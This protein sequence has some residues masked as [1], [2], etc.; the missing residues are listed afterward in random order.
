MW[1]CDLFVSINTYTFY[2]HTSSEASSPF[3]FNQAWS[4]MNLTGPSK[5]P[6]RGVVLDSPSPALLLIISDSIIRNICSR[7]AVTH[8]LPGA[9]ISDITEK[10]PGI[11]LKYPHVQKVIVLVGT[12]DTSLKQLEVL[13]HDFICLFNFLKVCEKPV[14]IS[15]PVPSF[16][17]CM[18]CFT[19]LQ[20][21]HLA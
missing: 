1:V 18:G 20:S 9:T 17:R 4:N 5:A 8:C 3:S 11:L 2:M 10:L 13:K 15:S 6:P 14:F 16:N 12:N 7:A 19:R 21:L